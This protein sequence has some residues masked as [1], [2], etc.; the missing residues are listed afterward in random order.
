M[1]IG[2]KVWS[3]NVLFNSFV[4][5]HVIHSPVFQLLLLKKLL[6]TALAVE[7]NING[8]KSS[9]MNHATTL[10]ILHVLN[11]EP[12]SWIALDFQRA[13]RR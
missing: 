12:P 1:G 2:S 13:S 7:M 3:L 8:K 10:D 9:I 11:P 6:A 5:L 4:T